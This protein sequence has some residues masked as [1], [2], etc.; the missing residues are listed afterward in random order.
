MIKYKKGGDIVKND[1]IYQITFYS[2]ALTPI[3]AENAMENLFSIGAADV[4]FPSVYSGKTILCILCKAP[5][6]NEILSYLSQLDSGAHI[7]EQIVCRFIL[8]R[9]F[10]KIHTPYGTVTNKISE[11]YDI[12]RSKLEYDD[13]AHIAKQA[14]ISIPYLKT[15]I[16]KHSNSMS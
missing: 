1:E 9:S 4:Y 7:Y 8:G 2:K 12:Q 13:L 11:G 15:Q 6:R 10:E 5:L 16:K 3:A 14:K